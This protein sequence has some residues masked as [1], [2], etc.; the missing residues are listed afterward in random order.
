MLDSEKNDSDDLKE[1]YDTVDEKIEDILEDLPVDLGQQIIKEIN[2]ADMFEDDYDLIKNNP[3]VIWMK[4]DDKIQK[5][6]SSIGYWKNFDKDE[7]YQQSYIYF[8]TLCKN[9]NPHYNG[10]FYPFDKYF[11]KNLI[12]KLRAYI[13]SYYFKRKREQPTDFLESGT[14]LISKDSSLVE[15]K[16]YMEYLLG[17]VSEKQKQVLLLHTQGYK[18]K[19]IGDMLGISQS[20]V[21]VIKKKTL[22]KIAEKIKKNM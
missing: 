19:E 15:D 6:T 7:L 5:I 17:L 4:Y 8:V 3:N 10:N 12:V 16:M 9:Y 11:F 18:Q 22:K 14:N 1:E 13:Q 21:S 20:R 2:T